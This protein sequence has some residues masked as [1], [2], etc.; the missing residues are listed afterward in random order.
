M[1]QIEI[2]Q[3]LMH[4]EGHAKTDATDEGMQELM[5]DPM[6]HMRTKEADACQ[7]GLILHV[8]LS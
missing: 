2:S 3:M 7:M 6:P 1:P 4:I 5:H 8:K